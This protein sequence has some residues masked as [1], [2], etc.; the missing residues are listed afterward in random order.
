M[1]LVTLSATKGH[2]RVIHVYVNR[3]NYW[4]CFEEVITWIPK[5]WRT[6]W[7]L[8]ASGF[9]NNDDLIRTYT[10]VRAMFD[11]CRPIEFNLCGEF[12]TIDVDFDLSTT[13]TVSNVVTVV[14]REQ[15]WKQK[16]LFRFQKWFCW[17]TEAEGQGLSYKPYI[18][19][20]ISKTMFAAMPDL[21]V[22]VCLHCEVLFRDRPN[23]NIYWKQSSK[24]SLKYI[25]SE[26]IS[27]LF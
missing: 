24:V 5:M 27:K 21:S 13:A 14:V 11:V 8:D 20:V 10:H 1:K 12:G 18:S 3:R 26:K 23:L 22:F 17:F 15:E 19:I 16:C 25:Q 6:T 4:R 2:A 7:K 9:W